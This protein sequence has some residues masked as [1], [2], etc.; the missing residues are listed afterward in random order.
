MGVPQGGPRGRGSR[1]QGSR[2]GRDRHSGP[3]RSKVGFQSPDLGPRAEGRCEIRSEDQG[4]AILQ[5]RRD[6][7]ERP[8]PDAVAL[9]PRGSA[10]TIDVNPH[11]TDARDRLHISACG[12]HVRRDASLES[13]VRARFQEGVAR[14]CPICG[15][16]SD[17]ERNPG[18]WRVETKHEHFFASAP[19]ERVPSSAGP[20]P[21][22]SGE[23]SGPGAAFDGSPPQPSRPAWRRR[24]RRSSTQRTSTA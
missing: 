8:Q 17:R 3:T 12:L 5:R 16:N 6:A 22:C 19:L 4:N 10:C 24:L 20:P 1:R 14:T 13:A 18:S 21:A 9:S 11:R 2:S 7:A 23:R 15:L